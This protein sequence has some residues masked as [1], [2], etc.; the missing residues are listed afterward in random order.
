MSKTTDLVALMHIVHDGVDYAEGEP[1]AAVPEK[2][3]QAL[4]QAGAARAADGDDDKAEVEAAREAAAKQAAA[5]AEAQQASEE[6]PQKTKA[7][8]K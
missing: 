2:Q 6:A 4:L 3:A 8:K 7:G 1:L 5:E